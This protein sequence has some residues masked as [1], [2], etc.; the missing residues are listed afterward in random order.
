MDRLLILLLFFILSGRGMAEG[1]VPIVFDDSAERLY[2]REKVYFLKNDQKPHTA[3]AILSGN[4]DAS[5]EPNQ[6]FGLN[7]GY[8]SRIQ[9]GDYWLAM[10]IENRTSHDIA[11]TVHSSSTPSLSRIFF[12]DESGGLVRTYESAQQ[13]K[14]A[15]RSIEIPP[16]RWKI[17]VEL[18]RDI[19]SHPIVYLGLRSYHNLVHSNPERYFIAISMGI[20]LSLL[21]YNFVLALTLRSR[22][23]FLYVGYNL[24]MVLFFE[25]HGQLLAEQFGTPEIPLWLLVPINTSCL[26][27]FLLFLNDILGVRNN[28]PGWVWPIRILLGLWPLILLI[29]AFNLPLAN[30]IVNVLV[31]VAGPFALALGVHAVIRKIMIARLLL[32]TISLP[33]LGAVIGILSTITGHWLPMPLVAS[34]PLIAI[35]L[36]MILLSMTVGYKIRQSH[37]SL[38]RRRDHAYSELKKIVYPHQVQRIWAGKS[39]DATMPLGRSEAFSLVFDVI[40]SSKLSM[41]DPR[42][43]LSDVFSTCSAIMME[44]YDGER[45]I[46]NAYR[47][48]EMG[49]GF[50]CTIGFPF[51]CPDPR[52]ADHSLRLAYRFMQ[53]FQEKARAHNATEPL[54]CAIGIAQGPVEAFYPENGAQVYDLFGRSIILAHRYEGMRDVLFPRLKV[55]DSIIILQKQVFDQLSPDLKLDF[56]VLNLQEEGLVVRD[57]EKAVELY[58]RLGVAADPLSGLQQSSPYRQDKAS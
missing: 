52:I 3:D 49:D 37:L 16:G 51:H 28:L 36:E 58:Y 13:L 22:S 34:A 25:G 2:L 11:L 43:F 17:Y 8:P 1:F 4:L 6:G 33:P 35:D 23:H 10:V 53:V 5:F 19:Y 26:F 38:K 27:L 47:V 14:R 50:L 39:L 21:I 15:G 24:A 7:L 44:E 55:R 20:C 48:K 42:K 12:L 30:R 54:H 31:A 56:S 46:A 41:E 40:G 57:D 18:T 9:V 29:G 45:L 32:V